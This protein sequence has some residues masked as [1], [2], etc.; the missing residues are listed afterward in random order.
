MIISL[1]VLTVATTARN[2]GG[3]AQVLLRMPGS[4][5]PYVLTKVIAERNRGAHP[6][7][8]QL[9]SEIQQPVGH[10]APATRAESC[11]CRM[12]VCA[13]EPR[14]PLTLYNDKK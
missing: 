9:A 3:G 2:C 10:T 8:A 12:K 5:R 11:R 6:C 14:A 1:R 7:V 13:S 4:E